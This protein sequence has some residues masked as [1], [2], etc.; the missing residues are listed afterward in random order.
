MSAQLAV[1]YSNNQFS[2]IV[3]LY[4]DSKK[5]CQEKMLINNIGPVAQ[6]IAV[7]FE[8]IEA[9][10]EQTVEYNLLGINIYADIKSYG[11]NFTILELLAVDIMNDEDETLEDAA[12]V[13]FNILAEKIHQINQQTE[14]QYANRY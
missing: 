3:P 1:K 11:W 8:D 4:P 5:E 2:K 6:K 14:Q 7:M 12:Q 10:V 13:L 9:N